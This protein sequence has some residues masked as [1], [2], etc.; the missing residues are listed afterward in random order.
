MPNKTVMCTF[1]KRPAEVQF[2]CGKCVINYCGNGGCRID[3]KLR[4]LHMEDFERRKINKK[5][6]SL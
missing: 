5:R 3:D 6:G 2:T 1:C 4:D